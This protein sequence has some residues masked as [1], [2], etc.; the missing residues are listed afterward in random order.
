MTMRRRDIA[1]LVL[2]AALWGGSFLFTRL[3]AADF[4]PVVLVFLRVAGAGALLLPLVLWRGEGGALRRHWRPIAMVGLF[5]S[6]LPFLL[7]A[8]GALVLNAGLSAIFNATSPLWGALIAWLWLR[9]RPA[10]LR[11]LGLAIGF[12]GVLGLGL[13]T[14]SFKPG[15]HGVSPALAVLACAAA[16]ACYGFAANYAKQRLV[17]VPPFAVAAGSQLSA[18]ALT[19]L[20]AVWFWP[21][22]NPGAMAWLGTAVLAFACTGLAYLLYFRLIASAGAANAISV[23]FLV[24]AFAVLWGALF[25]AERLTPAMVLGCAVILLGTAL[26]TGMFAPRLPAAQQAQPQQPGRPERPGGGLGHR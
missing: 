24:P 4:G 18:A 7:F 3:G 8:V 9:D 19:V 10:P 22:V 26:A 11:G 20:P 12:A 2:L 14:A 16:T 1:E 6:A 5:N 15:D 17:G 23:T 21:A 25:L 13:Q